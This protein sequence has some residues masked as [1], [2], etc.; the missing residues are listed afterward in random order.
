M[1]HGLNTDEERGGMRM[2]THMGFRRC[3]LRVSSV[4][5]IGLLL[6][7]PVVGADN[8]DARFAEGLRQRRLFPL[9]EAFCRERL[10]DA[11]LGEADRADLVIQL[12]RCYA[13]QAAHAIPADRQPLWQLARQAAADFQ[14]DQA[15]NPR[16]ILVRVQ[17][18]LTV[19]TQGEL[20]RLEAE[21]LPD[22]GISLEDAKRVLRDAGRILEQLDEELT[23]EIPARHRQP[24]RGEEL[25]ADELTALQHHVRWQ[26]S[27][28][29]RGLALCYASD[30]DDRIAMLTQAVRTL[31]Q[32]LTQLAAGEPLA[33]RFRIEQAG[34]YRLLGDF[35]AADQA[36]RQVQASA[37]QADTVLEA[38]AEA[39]RFEL[40]RGQPQK[41]LEVLSQGREIAGRVSP[42]LDFAHL[43]TYLALGRDAHDR[44]DADQA[45]TWQTKSVAMVKL[46]EQIHGPA[47]GRRSD[48]LL[49]HSISSGRGAAGLDV[50][51]RTGD[52]L[53]RKGQA[54]EA[55]V[56]YEKAAQAAAAGGQ[57]D[58]AFQLRY[59]A[60]LVDQNR[61][62]YGSAAVRLQ[63]LARDLRTQPKAAE[64]H[65]LA[66]WNAAQAARQDEAALE[67]YAEILSEHLTLWTSSTTCDSVH[68]WLGRLHERQHQWAAAAEAYHKVGRESE[69]AGEALPAA[70]RCWE[71]HLTRLR[72][73]GA[74]GVP[75]AGARRGTNEQSGDGDANQEVLESAAQTIADALAG[76]VEP[77]LADAARP[78]TAQDRLAAKSAARFLVQY[79]RH[80][81][82]QAESLLRAASTG[83][84]PP[85]A[86]WRATA[87]SLLV[88]ALAAQQGKHAEAERT[89]RQL[90]SLPP[91]RLA[92]L[93]ASLSAM[94]ESAS[95][96]EQREIAGLRLAAIETLGSRQSQLEA[97]VQARIERW[98]AESLA[99]VG[100]H[101][102]AVTAY[103]ILAAR[104]PDD[105]P[106]QTAYAQL[107]LSGDDPKS[108]KMALDHWRRIANRARPQSEVWY[109]A[110]FGTAVALS[111]LG[112]K[113]EAADRIL[114]LQATTPALAS[115]PWASRFAELLRACQ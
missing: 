55:I 82:A 25:A 77:L 52:N 51:I 23:R 30:S 113:R 2:G 101:A 31:G 35:A 68:L 12:L 84:P 73:E 59:K 56:A 86:A 83:N 10:A 96:G 109:Q 13:A 64:A 33:D 20:L 60:A 74:P 78:W 61:Q 19:V 36:L 58:Q 24:P 17:D 63:T 99:A 54:D 90:G 21:F 3:F 26:R 29:Q 22:P 27:R 100:R 9:A 88:L 76:R 34:C 45:D 108:W 80:G 89:L 4:A 40:A 50:L 49:V 42:E 14:R 103:G 11:Q 46:V 44:G 105:A 1:K 87:E 72:A 93:V 114:Y 32:G 91:E 69:H 97:S 95:A 85:D 70:V 41:A 79:N 102:E 8:E 47:W 115:T 106:L 28:A 5:I 15:A 104:S 16:R 6:G 66:A 92:E 39:A 71:E 43:E 37:D 38:R 7:L 94:A 107:L 65:L 110:K 81:G 98:R 67:R 53:Y 57:A 62:R 111:K 112:Q 18:A 48:L 75:L